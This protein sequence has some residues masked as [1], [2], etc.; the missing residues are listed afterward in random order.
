MSKCFRVDDIRVAEIMAILL[1][2]RYYKFNDKITGLEYYTFKRVKNI[3][4]IYGIAMRTIN[5]I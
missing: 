2:N 3:N 5:K 1:G 4:K